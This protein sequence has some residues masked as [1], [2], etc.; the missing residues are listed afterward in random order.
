MKTSSSKKQEYTYSLKTAAFA[1]NG[2]LN[3]DKFLF[4]ILP[5]QEVIEIKKLR[6]ILKLQF[7]SAIP[8]ADRIIEKIGIIS[9]YIYDENSASYFKC[10]EI[11]KAADANREVELDIDLTSLLKPDNVRYNS[12]LYNFG[13]YSDFTFVWLKLGRGEN[14]TSSFCGILEK[15]K[16]D[17]LFI[18][19]G[20]K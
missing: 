12:G 18:T 1:A 11:N 8:T 17:A 19:K 9:D 20:V 2:G 6:T 10:F 15:W 14:L 13:L 4:Y 3:F 7:D 5:P 16:I